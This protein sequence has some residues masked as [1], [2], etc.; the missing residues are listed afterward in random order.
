M[1]STI[2]FV[3]SLVAY[4]FA[5]VWTRYTLSQYSSDDGNVAGG[6]ETDF[7]GPR[8]G[9]HTSPTRRRATLNEL[10]K[11]TTRNMSMGISLL[12]RKYP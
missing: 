8:R 9:P 3:L 6:E 10:G 5:W 4:E 12:V 1:K 2:T 11:L 7:A